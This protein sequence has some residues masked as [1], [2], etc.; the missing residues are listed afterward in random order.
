M[1]IN[2]GISDHNRKQISQ[3]LSGYLANTYNLYLKTQN[4]HWNVTGAEFYS[5]HLLFEMQYQAMAEEIDEV[6]ERIRSLGFPVDASFSAFKEIT[7]IKD[8]GK[9]LNTKDMLH[10]LVKGHEIL[11]KHGRELAEIAEK[12]QDCGTVDMLGRRVGEHEKMLWMIR[13]HLSV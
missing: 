6:A 3:G 5:L 12:E 8:E 4:F 9:K 7:N 10:S 1:K 11:I 13:S 2:I